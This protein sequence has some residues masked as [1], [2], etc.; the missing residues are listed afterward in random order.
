MMTVLIL[1][2]ILGV[3]VSIASIV[4]KGL[5]MNW[6]QVHSVK[7]LFASE[8]GMERILYETR[9]GDLLDFNDLADGDCIN[10]DASGDIEFIGTHIQGDSDCFNGPNEADKI[11]TMSNAAEYRLQHENDDT[12]F[13]NNVTLTS[14]GGYM[15][16]SRVIKSSYGIP[17]C[18]AVVTT[19]E[20]GC[21]A[22]IVANSRDSMKYCA[23]NNYCYECVYGYENCDLNPVNGCETVMG[24][25]TNCT[26]CGQMCTFP[27]VCQGYDS[28]GCS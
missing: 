2:S 13:F 23:G 21:R 8:G 1:T 5:S 17:K 24:T 10:F 27:S 16:Q 19:T 7:A 26:V 4:T 6:E 18:S 11:I 12:G 20:L 25:D 9:K 14:Y 3:T 15:R 22:A 28:A